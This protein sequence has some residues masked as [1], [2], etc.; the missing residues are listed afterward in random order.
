MSKKVVYW[1]P[2]GGWP[3]APAYGTKRKCK[4][5]GDPIVYV[6][7]IHI[8]ESAWCHDTEENRSIACIAVFAE[9]ADE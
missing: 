8:T 6:E 5:C 7:G 4:N 2:P 9:P 3:V 1:E